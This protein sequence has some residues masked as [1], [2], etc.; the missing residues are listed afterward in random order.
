MERNEARA[1]AIRELFVEELAEVT[2]GVDPLEKVRRLV[3]EY[4][5]T[6]YGC[7]EEVISPC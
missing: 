7:G 5:V 1:P 4:L 3:E 6:T 2:G